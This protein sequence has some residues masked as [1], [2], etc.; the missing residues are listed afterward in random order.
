M[1]H[2]SDGAHPLLDPTTRLRLLVQRGKLF[3]G[4]KHHVG[5]ALFIDVEQIVRTENPAIHPSVYKGWPLVADLLANDPEET[6]F[7]VSAASHGAKDWHASRQR[8]GQ[9]VDVP[10]V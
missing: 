10:T 8:V 3:R 9:I 1:P 6:V 5:V 2:A 4:N 7:A